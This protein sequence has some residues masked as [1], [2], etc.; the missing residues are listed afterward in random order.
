MIT[1]F[2]RDGYSLLLDEPILYCSIFFSS[3]I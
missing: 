3:K 2:K 1:E